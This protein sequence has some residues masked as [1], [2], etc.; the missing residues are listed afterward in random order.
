MAKDINSRIAALRQ[1]RSGADRVVKVPEGERIAILAKSRLDESWQKRATNKPYT[2]Y[3]LGAMAEVDVDYTR[4]SIETAHRVGGQL[5]K[6]FEEEARSAVFRLQGSVPLNVH[7]RGVSDVDLLAIETSLL[8]YHTQGSKALRGHYVPTEVTSLETLLSLRKSC[9]KSLTRAYP[10]ATVDTSGSKAIKLSGGSLP[11]PVDVVPSHWYDNIPYQD[12]ENESDRGVVI[13][14]CAIPETIQNFPFLHIKLVTERCDAVLGSLR[15][16]IRLCK[17]IKADSEE[18]GLDIQLSSFDIASIMY[19]ADKIALTAGYL[20]EL[21][22]LAETQ[23]HLDYLYSHSDYAKTLA[24]PD[25]S[26]LIFDQP[27]KMTALLHLSGQVDS[28]LREVAREQNEAIARAT[29]IALNESRD[30]VRSIKVD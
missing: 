14:N 26:R 1:R 29:N 11:R 4:I 24:V 18:D 10:A 17:N 9:E 20:Y 13:L 25:G 15:K 12:T 8:T 16:S 7:I 6:S 5:A 28:L 27:G 21:A 3:A 23:K 30:A 2:R 19:H 22:I